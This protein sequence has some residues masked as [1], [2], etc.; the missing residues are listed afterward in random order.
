MNPVRLFTAPVFYFLLA[1][2]IFLHQYI[3][4]GIIWEWNE[5]LYGAAYRGHRDL[6][7]EFISRGDKNYRYNW[8]MAMKYA[9]AGRHPDLVD[10][11][12]QKMNQYGQK[13]VFI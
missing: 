11:F 12:R 7:N 3:V 6:V 13:Y 10:F 5:V 2:L 4:W 1:F 9:E 8:R